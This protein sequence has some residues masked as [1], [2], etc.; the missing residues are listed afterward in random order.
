ASRIRGG[1]CRERIPRARAGLRRL[2]AA[3]GRR[4]FG[5]L[6]VLTNLTAIAPPPRPP[7][8]AATAAIG[9]IAAALGP[10]RVGACRRLQRRGGARTI[11][12]HAFERAGPPLIEVEAARHRLDA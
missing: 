7:P 12:H 9:G 5:G 8:P 10:L 4:V 11:H 6:A 3:A 1:V 2:G